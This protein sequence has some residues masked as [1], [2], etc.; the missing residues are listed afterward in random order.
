MI[1]LLLKWKKSLN[2]SVFKK[3][4]FCFCYYLKKSIMVVFVEIEHALL[5]GCPQNEFICIKIIFLH[6]G[7]V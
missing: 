1:I 3:T 4:I 7:I 6:F 2:D 5:R